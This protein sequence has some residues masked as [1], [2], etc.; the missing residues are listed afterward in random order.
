VTAL[1][2]TRGTDENGRRT[3]TS[4]EGHRITT[5]GIPSWPYTLY[6]R[7]GSTFIAHR[8]YVAKAEAES[9]TDKDEDMTENT[10]TTST[11]ETED[12]RRAALVGPWPMDGA[13]ALAST[14]D[15]GASAR[16]TAAV[17]RH[18][19]AG[20]TGAAHDSPAVR[21]TMTATGRKL[22]A[23]TVDLETAAPVRLWV[24]V[25]GHPVVDVDP[26]EDGP[27][28]MQWA[29]FGKYVA[30]SMGGEP[31]WD[32]ADMLG[33]FDTA[34]RTMLHLDVSADGVADKRAELERWR[35]LG[36]TVGVQYGESL[37]ELFPSDDDEDEDYDEDEDDE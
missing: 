6:Y 21:V 4:D 37:D 33:D 15:Y 26:D 32:G 8:L 20:A 19:A 16:G 35:A 18:G 29:R 24:R 27:G 14:A 34:A 13:H 3:Y 36:A 23:T 17:F 9:D 31:D 28:M 30:A 1:T 10:S 12:K 5:D 22:A 11:S 7:D 25:N 2:W